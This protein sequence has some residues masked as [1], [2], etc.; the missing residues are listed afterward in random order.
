MPR[1]LAAPVEEHED[2][3][4]G[5]QAYI[6]R[7]PS[8]FLRFL[9]GL[10]AFSLGVFVCGACGSFVRTDPSWNSAV[11]E[12]D[13]GT[14]SAL[15]IANLFGRPGA[16][17]ADLLTQGFGWCAWL[18]GFALMIGG[19]RRTLAIGP[20]EPSRWLWGAL[21]LT[22][23]SVSLAEWP[24]PQSWQVA[25][26]LGGVV[27]GLGWRSG[28]A[29][30]GRAACGTAGGRRSAAARTGFGPG[31][32]ARRRLHHRSAREA[33]GRGSGKRNECFAAPGY[34]ANNIAHA[35]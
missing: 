29:F 25:A 5:G 27:G 21:G 13:P 31:A 30:A 22:L 19:L 32:R 33:R 11:P 14:G 26:S 8:A 3:N 28:L 2:A 7:P 6:A 35:V 9:T 24:I 1:A 23:A 16:I 12:I 10:G 20:R 17:S 18:M 34:G 15:E 4:A